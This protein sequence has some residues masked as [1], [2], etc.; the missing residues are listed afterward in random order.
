ML[1]KHID[2]EQ[3]PVVY[4]GTL[5]DPDGDPRCRTMVSARFKGER[6]KNNHKEMLFFLCVTRMKMAAA[7]RCCLLQIKYGGTV[8]RSYY[9]QDAVKVQYD[10]SVTISRG[11]VFQLEFEVAAAS[12]LLRYRSDPSDQ[13]DPAWKVH[14]RELQLWAADDS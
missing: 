9:V 12:S 2:P 1:R 13:S 4:G 6:K 8:P 10:R 14:P 7:A 5:T 3:L 11:S